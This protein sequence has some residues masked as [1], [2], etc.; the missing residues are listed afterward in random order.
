M[1]Q[2]ICILGIGYIGLPT[3]AI[4]ADKGY[5]VLAV[6]INELIV[7][8]LN[9]GKVLI[10]EPRLNE[11]VEQVVRKGKLKA[12]LVPEHS[13]IFIITVPTPITKD[14]KADLSNVIDATKSILPFLKKESIVILES[15]SPVGTTNEIVIPILAESGLIIGE[16]IFVGYSPER[17][18]PG[19][20][21]NELINN[22][23]VIGGTNKRSAEKIKDL[24]ATF[25]KGELYLT[26]TNTAEMCK[27]MENTFRDVNIALANELVKICEK[28]NIN[29]WE[30]IELSNKHP[31]VNLHQ[32][33]PGV[34]GHCLPIDPWF[35][36]EK[37]PKLSN[38]IKLS[39]E[40]NST[41]PMFVA[42]KIEKILEDIKGN[43]KIT[44]LGITYKPN[45]DDLRESPII[46]I[47]N[48]L[49]G[50]NYEIS[51]FDPFVNDYKYSEADILKACEASDLI[52]LGVNHKE[53]ENLDFNSIGLN[54]RNK[55]ILDTRK[56]LKD[57]DT[58]HG[59]KYYLLGTS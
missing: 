19:N 14:K 20:I 41:M 23:R 30:V 37:E 7:D 3:A 51:I 9:K 13:D 54:M 43:K 5:N 33:G 18:L 49:E 22:S 27:L 53:F 8:N 34:G 35:I 11:I 10:E 36:I 31:R 46:D 52:L 21:I 59:F 16:E 42:N 40:I 58:M 25:V 57:N 56:F 2:K 15:T 26:D 29:A 38:I 47:I 32:P 50:R 45:T 17:V 39:R 1:K 6:D 48:I 4:L 44:I 55:N 28:T 24:Y 12:N